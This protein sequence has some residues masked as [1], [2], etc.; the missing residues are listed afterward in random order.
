MKESK[1]LEMQNQIKAQSAILQ[2]IINEITHL[3]E[4]SVGTLET[5]KLMPDYKDAIEAL[6]K[7]ME[8]NIKERKKAEQNGTIEQDTE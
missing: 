7:Q 3:R 6:K 2:Q 5:I 1:L 8:D 4:L